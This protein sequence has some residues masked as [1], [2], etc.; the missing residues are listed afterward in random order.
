M[1]MTTTA[2]NRVDP[3]LSP[4]HLHILRHSLGLDDAGHGTEYR[5]YYCAAVENDP[6]AA[7]VLLGLMSAGRTINGG[8]CRYYHVTDKGKAVVA[9]HKP[10]EPI[11]TRSQKRYRAWLSADLGISFREYLRSYT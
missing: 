1:I 4:E 10:P 6:C 8:T 2:T 11:L 5:N 9:E 3:A 7:L